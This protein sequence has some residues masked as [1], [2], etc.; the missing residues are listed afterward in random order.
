MD[1]E[2]LLDLSSREQIRDCI[3]RVSRGEDRRDAQ[4][5]KSCFWPDAT[6]D[7]GIFHGSLDEYLD[8]VVPGAE[9]VVL[10]Q[11]VLGQHLIELRGAVALVETHVTAYHRID[12][13]SELSSS[14]WTSSKAESSASSH[15]MASPDT[16]AVGGE[17]GEGCS[18][19]PGPR[20]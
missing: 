4:L 12:M 19:R 18:V 17:D 3:A 11:H 10:T 9:A 5:L 16:F 7:H 1:T 2:Q 6:D 13:G 8:W 14:A 20:A 15:D